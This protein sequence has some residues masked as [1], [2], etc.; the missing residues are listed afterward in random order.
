MENIL[1]LFFGWFLGLFSPKIIEE[2]RKPYRIK[3]IKN[4]IFS[5]LT[6]VKLR[7]AGIVF[8]LS[9]QYYPLTKKQLSWLLPYLEEHDRLYSGNMA[10][11]MKAAYIDVDEDQLKA[12]IS[13]KMIENP[14][15]GYRLKLFLLPFLES[16]ID[17]MSMFDLGFQRDV[18]KLKVNISLLN[19]EIN[20]SRFYYDK[21]FE[22]LTQNNYDIIK[23]NVSDSYKNIARVSKVLVEKI[24]VFISKYSNGE[25]VINLFIKNLSRKF[26]VK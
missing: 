5:E 14:S 19:D 1:Y 23:K 24:D 8:I 25:D 21:T 2:I 18:M 10:K 17:S 7:M 6:E 15:P 3:E 12:A 4:G 9:P 22:N 16:Q 13:H 20:N 11:D 26:K